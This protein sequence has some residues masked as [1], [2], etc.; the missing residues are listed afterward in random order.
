[1]WW[2]ATMCKKGICDKG[3]QNN[4][5]KVLIEV[6]FLSYICFLPFLKFEDC[7][8]FFFAFFFGTFLDFPVFL[9]LGYFDFLLFIFAC[10][11]FFAIFFSIFCVFSFFHIFW[12][13][14]HFAFFPLF[15]M[16]VFFKKNCIFRH[17][18]HFYRGGFRKDLRMFQGS[19]KRE[20]QG[21]FKEV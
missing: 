12:A 9:C 5:H 4:K 19:F 7:S 20:F 16:F 3:S 18:W 17:F 6:E 2:R 14:I 1:M 21:Y 10:F 11:I 15:R 13:F 8:A